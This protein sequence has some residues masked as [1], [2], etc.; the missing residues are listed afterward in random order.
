MMQRRSLLTLGMAGLLSACRPN[1]K[2]AD[3]GKA[4]MAVNAKA[5][6]VKTL[7]SGLQYKVVRTGPTDGLRPQATDEVKVNYEGKL[8]DGTIFDSSYQR[9]VPAALPLRA[10]IPG[11]IEALQLMHPGDE[12]IL[13]VPPELGYGNDGAGQIPPGSTLI[14]RIELIAVLPGVG[15]IGQG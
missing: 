14:F 1:S 6:G 8:L 5:E 10:L 13:Y 15:R 7:K 4:F 9:G 2:N 3:A 11:W 12:W